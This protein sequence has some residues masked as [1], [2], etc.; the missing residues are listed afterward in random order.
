M[1][2]A[3][4]RDNTFV[5]TFTADGNPIH[6]LTE[7][8]I[9]ARG[10]YDNSQFDWN[11]YLHSNKFDQAYATGPQPPKDLS[12]YSYVGSYGKIINVRRIGA[13]LEG[14]EAVKGPGDTIVAIP[15]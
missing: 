2:G 4:I 15:K 10:T 7:G 1:G 5:N 8:H 13:V 6:L 14:E 3:V 12:E 9:R 11:A